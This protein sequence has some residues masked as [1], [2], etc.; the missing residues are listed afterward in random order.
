MKEDNERYRQISKWVIATAAVCCLIFLGIRYVGVIAASIKWGTGLVQPLLIGLILALMLNVP[1]SF[2]EKRLLKK[3]NLQKGKRPLSIL[4]AL[5]LV[6][7]IFI[8][9]SFLVIPELVE[10]AKL[11]ITIITG[12]IDQLAV[13]ESSLPENALGGFLGRWN[14]D[15]LGLKAQLDG[16]LK[17]QSDVFVNQAVG[18]AGSVLSSV[19]TA[20]ISLTFSIY[21]LTNKETLKR[22]TAR[23][24]RAWLPA[25]LTEPVIHIASVWS[26]T[27]KR[28]VAGQATEAIILG[29]LCMIRMAILRIPYVPMIGALVGVTALIPCGRCLDRCYCGHS[30]DFDSRPIQGGGISDFPVGPATGGVQCHLSQSGGF[31][32]QSSRHLGTGRCHR[33]RQS[34]RLHWHAP[35]GSSSFCRLCATKRGYPKS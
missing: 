13:M 26:D 35:G 27:F 8:G 12:G 17:G 25:K 4:L 5:I 18:A 11:I 14:I 32:N 3:S 24:M 33:R 7:G 10:A 20:V 34:G 16:W 19:V 9:I 2:V 1:M 29:T 15:W 22:Q 28:F 23:L 31:Q 6:L 21:I 30:D